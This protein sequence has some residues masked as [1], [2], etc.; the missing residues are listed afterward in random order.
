MENTDLK[1]RKASY[2]SNG[3][4]ECVEVGEA[5]RGVLV[6]DTKDRTGPVLRFSSAAWRRFADRLKDGRSLAGLTR[7]HKATL[8]SETAGGGLWRF[9]W[10]WASDDNDDNACCFPRY[11]H[12]EDHWLLCIFQ[13]SRTRQ[14]PSSL[15]L[16]RSFRGPVTRVALHL[17]PLLV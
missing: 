11:R 8:A 5:R 16:P 17:P 7:T 2:S 10:P 15:R 12:G 13:R 4:G 1:W 14:N 6:R 9:R 3:G